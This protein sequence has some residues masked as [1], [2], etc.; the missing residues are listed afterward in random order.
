MHCSNSSDANSSIELLPAFPKP[1]LDTNRKQNSNNP[2][3]RKKVT[4]TL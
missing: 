3:N 4:N 1:R 2:R